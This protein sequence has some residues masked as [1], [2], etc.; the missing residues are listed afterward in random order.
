MS[1]QRRP[2]H[3]SGAAAPRHPFCPLGGWSAL[4][5]A[6]AV[7]G[8]G[9]WWLSFRHRS[10]EMAVEVAALEP[11]E[12]ALREA[13]TKAPADLEASRSLGRYLLG[14]VRP[15]EAMWAKGI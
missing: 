3:Q 9:A 6:L 7:I 14:R 10:T 5:L 12:R 13:V 4:L 1:T 15:Y 8:G 11:Q 2:R